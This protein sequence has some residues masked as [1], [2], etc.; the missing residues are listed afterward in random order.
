[1]GAA[2]QRESVVQ[3]PGIVVPTREEMIVKGL[4]M[5]GVPT[6]RHNG[7]VW[8]QEQDS[9]GWFLESPLF[10]LQFERDI[11][12]DQRPWR[13]FVDT[14]PW[15]NGRPDPGRLQGFERF[16]ANSHYLVFTREIEPSSEYDRDKITVD[17][18]D[19]PVMV[20]LSLR[21][22]ENDVRHDWR[23]MQ[24]VKNEVLGP[25]W[26]GV[27]MYPSEARVVDTANQYHLWCIQP[28]AI[29]PFGFNH[30]LRLDDGEHPASLVGGAQRAFAEASTG[31]EGERD[32]EHRAA[33]QSYVE[34]RL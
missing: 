2:R 10:G 6:I 22:V 14:I 34:E 17:D 13:P 21:T 33:S 12:H 23:E 8:R 26:E 1:M 31:G 25:D 32:Q 15:S 30:S 11:P 7:N 16:F 27:E 20:H 19:A 24:R 3:G 5:E 29:F 4:R 28:P 9:Q 18:P